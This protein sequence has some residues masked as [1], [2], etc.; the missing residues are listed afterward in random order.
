MTRYTF[1]S[2][3][4]DSTIRSLDANYIAARAGSNLDANDILPTVAGAG[5]FFDSINFV[6]RQGFL[7]YSHTQIPT[8]ELA[9]NAALIFEGFEHLP[10]G[11]PWMLEAREYD[12][13]GTVT[14][15]TW[16]PG[17]DITNVAPS[18][19][20]SY[21][22]IREQRP[23]PRHWRA[24]TAYFRQ[25]LA[26]SSDPLRLLLN[27]NKLWIGWTPGG[28]GSQKDEYVHWGTSEGGENFYRP[29]IDYQTTRLTSLTRTE[30][31]SVQLSDG[32]TV[33]L[34]GSTT[35][36]LKH[37]PSGTTYNTIGTLPIGTGSTQFRLR[38]GAQVFSLTRDASDNIYVV[39]PNGSISN[40]I[41]VQ[42]FVK[43]SGYTWT[44]KTVISGSL[45]TYDGDINQIVSTW[46]NAGN[47][48][49]VAVVAHS[50]GNDNYNNQTVV[51][52]ISCANARLGSGSAITYTVSMVPSYLGT[53]INAAGN[54]LDV[55]AVTETT[56]S[57]AAIASDTPNAEASTYGRIYRY[58]INTLGTLSAISNLFNGVFS[59]PV[60]GN[61]RAKLIPISTTRF[62]VF[63]YGWVRVFSVT[64]STFTSAGSVDMTT[65][66][67]ATMALD[68][69]QAWDAIYDRAANKVWIYYVDDADA[70]RIMRTG[71]DPNSALP[72]LSETQVAA[73]TGASGSSTHAIRIPQSTVDERR[74]I[75]HL[76]NRTGAGVNSTVTVFDTTL[77]QAPITPV[78]GEQPTFSAVNPRQFSWIFS[79]PN[80]SDSQ[81]AYEVEI[82]DASSLVSEYDPGKVTSTST[83]FILPGGTLSNNETY[84]WRVKTYDINDS[85]SAWS[86]W[87]SFSTTTAGVAEIIV[88]A[89]DNETGFS[90]PTLTIEWTFT[91]ADPQAEFRVRVVRTDTEA[92]IFDSGYIVGPTTTTYTV[93][94]L[95][96]DVE[97]RIELIVEDSATVASNTATRLVTPSFGA[98]D[99][100]LI[101]AAPMEDESGVLIT[102]TNPE[103]TEFFPPAG[104][105]DIYRADTGTDI[106]VKIGETISGGT[107]ID[108]TAATNTGYDYRVN[109]VADG[110]S[111]SNVVED[112]S[113]SF[114]GLYLHLPTD[115]V[116][117]VRHFLYGGSNK[118][119]NV[120][121]EGTELRF[122]GRTYSVWEYGEHLSEQVDV[123]IVVPFGDTHYE[124]LEYL[125]EVVRSNLTWCYRD[126]R[127]RRVF[128][129]INE[130]SIKDT[131]YGTD[132]SFTVARVEFVEAHP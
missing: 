120:A 67:I 45:P 22:K 114:K 50:Q 113:I 76:G 21:P 51:A 107:F 108:Y 88:P 52:S 74:I 63:W 68:A 55:L 49:L 2:N 69:T 112:V 61:H 92:I 24:G 25:R 38:D 5:Q 41:S 125:R 116:N 110:Q 54:G 53:T 78:L 19:I 90:A 7:E 106:W 122:A 117:T 127:S 111:E 83:S 101:T 121:T 60:D 8:T 126:G 129:V 57:I 93:S 33:F 86:A 103:P 132:V 34:D 37:N 99:E 130:V 35:P 46:H 58:T 128:G 6:L 28:P 11:D 10:V 62:A 89:T 9:T 72:D 3:P 96:S 32:T 79:D 77:N 40:G 17:N 115:A 118:S 84:E 59:L 15:S 47:G 109:A 56:G 94:G 36:I 26:A 123:N 27:S 104:R 119:D 64:P 105:N 75:V 65:Q 95:L 124:D 48:W 102:I 85:A 66:G 30:S 1:K 82:R 12:W 131:Q 80:P 73:A 16:V 81:S 39:G 98:P 97:Q 70:R 4:N 71:F 23:A 20:A 42:A 14:D 91:G 100:P 13:G 87:T 43:G 31:A 44:Q 18:M 29:R